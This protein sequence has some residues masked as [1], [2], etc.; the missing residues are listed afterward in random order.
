MQWSNHTIT[1]S[2]SQSSGARLAEVVRVDP[3]AYFSSERTYVQWMHIS[4]T[5]GAIS[6]SL[7]SLAN[8]PDVHVAGLL[9]LGPALFVLAYGTV[10]FYRRKSA[11]DSTTTAALDDRVGPGLLTLLMIGVVGTNLMFVLRKAWARQDDFDPYES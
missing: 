10:T 11:L 8:T 1:P 9:L 4:L 5:L 7:I 6:L 3:K 2:P